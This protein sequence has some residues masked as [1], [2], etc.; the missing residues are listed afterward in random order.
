[1]FGLSPYLLGG[2]AAVILALGSFGGCQY[3]LKERAIAGEKKALHERDQARSANASQL[4]TIGTQDKALK[5]WKALHRTPEEIA[6]ILKN[7]QAYIDEIDRLTRQVELHRGRDKNLPDCIRLLSMSLSKLCPGTAYSL[8]LRAAG[9]D[10]DSG[11]SHP[12]GEGT[13]IGTH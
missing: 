9:K 3:V 2:V 6:V 1:V 10:G 13:A 5:Q 4:V 11:G 12:G 7:G 8:R